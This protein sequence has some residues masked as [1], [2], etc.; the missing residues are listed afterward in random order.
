MPVLP[1]VASTMVVRPGSIRPSASAA[2]IIATPI[3]SFTL[4]AGLYDSSLPISSAPQ[5]GAT[6]VKRTSGVPPTRS[7]RLA[8]LALARGFGTRPRLSRASVKI[9]AR[10]AVRRGE[11]GAAG[12]VDLVEDLVHRRLDA[13]DSPPRNR[14]VVPAL[15][16]LDRDVD[17]P[18]HVHDVVRC[19]EDP[20]GREVLG[21]AVVRELVVR[22]AAHDPCPDPADV[23]LVDRAAE[24]ARSHQ[25]DL[26]EEGAARVRPARAEPLRERALGWI[27]VS[28]QQLRARARETLRELRS[29]VAGTDDRDAPPAQVARPDLTRAAGAHRRLDAASRERARV[30]A[31]AAAPPEA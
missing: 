4:P 10:E 22:R 11:R 30:A 24:G 3:R 17:Q 12:R 15:V 1:D 20:A 19:V 14:G 7:A 2:S 25:V 13:V 29:H 18:A 21:E 5:S 6:R 28:E 31:A 8:G 27:Y 9:A 23:H 26:G 16:E